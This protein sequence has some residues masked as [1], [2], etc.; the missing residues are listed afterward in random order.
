M[1]TERRDVRRVRLAVLMIEG[2]EIG[3]G[4]DVEIGSGFAIE[5]PNVA[6]D[7]RSDFFRGENLHREDIETR[8]MKQIKRAPKIAGGEEIADEHGDAPTRVSAKKRFDPR[9]NRDGAP[10]RELF[11]KSEKLPRLARAHEGAK[12]RH[13]KREGLWREIRRPRM[14]ANERE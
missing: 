5:E 1:S 3:G 8:A 10:R 2:E 9:V 11:E 13:A 6:R 7:L 12:E 14:D 4:T